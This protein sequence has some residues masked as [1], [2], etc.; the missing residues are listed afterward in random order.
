MTPGVDVFALSFEEYFPRNE[1]L[2]LKY[3]DHVMDTYI[4]GPID[5]HT[6]LVGSV[7]LRGHQCDCI[8]QC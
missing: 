7:E 5:M 6:S 8:N 1:I 4:I 3:E 2:C